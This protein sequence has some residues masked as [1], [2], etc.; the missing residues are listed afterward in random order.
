[1]IKTSSILF[2]AFVLCLGAFPS[3]VKSDALT[4]STVQ[5]VG[6]LKPEQ[7]V[8]KKDIE[9]SVVEEK[10]TILK[11]KNLPDTGEIKDLI[12]MIGG[13][14]LLSITLLTC[15][16]SKQVIQGQYKNIKGS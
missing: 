5:V 15:R 1:M 12:L 13:L 9:T 16:L 6:D 2:I 10:K 8:I 7:E 11:E 3:S 4:R 14:L